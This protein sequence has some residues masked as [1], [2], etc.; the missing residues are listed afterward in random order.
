LSIVEYTVQST[1]IRERLEKDFSDETPEL[2]GLLKIVLTFAPEFFQDV[3]GISFRVFFTQK[4]LQDHAAYCKLL[5]KAIRFKL[6]TD[7]FVII[8]KAG[9]DESNRI[10]K[11]KLIIHELHHIGRDEEGQPEIR[12]HNEKEDFCELPH[13]DLFS[14]RVVQKLKERLD[15]P[16]LEGEKETA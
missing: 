3:Q 11:A 16:Q 13:H 14:E 12:K 9:F 5:P 2:Q 15:Q 7:F 4:P 8:D 1:A 6:K 10:D